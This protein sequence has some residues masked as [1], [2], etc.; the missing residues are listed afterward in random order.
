MSAPGNSNIGAYATRSFFASFRSSLVQGGGGL[1]GTL[2]F[3]SGANPVVTGIVA[4]MLESDPTL[5]AAEVQDILGRTARQDAFTG[6]VPNPEWGSGKI[7]AFAAVQE[8]LRLKAVKA[9]E[10]R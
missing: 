5:D 7:D 3:V 10:G 2:G 4:L 6:P 8:V 1:Y 9:E